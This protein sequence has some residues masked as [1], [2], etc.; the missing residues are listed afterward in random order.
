M[1]DMS[2]LAMFAVAFLACAATVSSKDKSPKVTFHEMAL[3]MRNAFN[4]GIVVEQ[5]LHGRL[6]GDQDGYRKERDAYDCDHVEA[7]LGTLQDQDGDSKS[8]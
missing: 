3:G 4:C 1:A 5:Y 2:K 6:K 8:Q 7:V